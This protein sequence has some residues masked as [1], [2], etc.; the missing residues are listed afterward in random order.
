MSLRGEGTPLATAGCLI[1]G[2]VGLAIGSFLQWVFVF[3]LRLV[4]ED[5][6]KS[7]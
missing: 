7:R 1:L 3:A 6:G 2:I 4:R 5:M